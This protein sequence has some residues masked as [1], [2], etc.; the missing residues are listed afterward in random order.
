MIREAGHHD[1]GMAYETWKKLD[2][3]LILRIE[4]SWAKFPRQCV[5]IRTRLVATPLSFS[6]ILSHIPHGQQYFPYQR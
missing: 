1:E 2:T 6:I 5:N 3:G 4:R